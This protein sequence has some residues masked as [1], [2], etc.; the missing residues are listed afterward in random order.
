M[1]IV[2]FGATGKTGRAFVEQALA[3]GHEVTA[4][5][6]NADAL[7]LRHEHL[8]VVVGDSTGDPARVEAAVQGQDAVVSSLGMRNALSSGG[9][10]AR[11]LAA[12]IPAMQR[13]GVTRLMMVSAVGV[14]ETRRQAPILPRIMYR[15]LLTDIFADKK[16][17][18]DAIRASGLDW[19]IA[20][21]T[22]LTD[23]P[24]TG[25][26]RTGERVGLSGFPRIARADVAHFLLAALEA[27]TWRRKGVIVT[28]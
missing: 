25:N 18:E 28:Y 7:A 23:G 17:G 27:G 16:V 9:L 2:V 5:V 26:Y 4:F 13:A 21:P 6:R 14:G 19:T 1:R 11:S 10:I 3:K 12:I 8:R 20:Y 15:L 22:L 24:M